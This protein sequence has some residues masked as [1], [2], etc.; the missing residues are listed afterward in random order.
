MIM[1]EMITMRGDV[2]GQYIVLAL[3]A[4]SRPDSTYEIQ[5]FDRG[6]FGCA[7]GVR[8][9]I[10]RFDADRYSYHDAADTLGQAKAMIAFWHGPGPEGEL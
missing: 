8:W 1:A 7:N 2:R 3:G 10:R 6:T 5:R 9:C 4:D